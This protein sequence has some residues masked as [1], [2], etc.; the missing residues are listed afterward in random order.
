MRNTKNLETR[1]A[2]LETKKAPESV[3]LRP[4]LE[5]L[6]E[7]ELDRLIAARKRLEEETVESLTDEELS[8][9][10]RIEWVPVEQV[11]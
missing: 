3:Q 4:V 6:T 11:A 1:V 8:L 2:M 5:N 10:Q 9:I 7:D